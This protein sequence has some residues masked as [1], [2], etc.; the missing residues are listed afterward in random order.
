MVFR[1]IAFSAAN[2]HRLAL[3][4]CGSVCF[5]FAVGCIFMPFGL[6]PIDSG[7]DQDATETASI[8]SSLYLYAKPDHAA[9]E[10]YFTP[11]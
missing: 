2:L 8:R 3:E 9:N 5:Y 11:K 4:L 7:V 6:G 10:N 1:D